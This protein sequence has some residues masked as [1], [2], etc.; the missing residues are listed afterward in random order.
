M[1]H[2]WLVAIA[3]GLAG[4]LAAAAPASA[5]RHSGHHSSHSSIGFH[6]SIGSGY[7]GWGISTNHFDLRYST[8]RYYGYSYYRPVYQPVVCD[9]PVYYSRPVY[10]SPAPVYVSPAPVYVS[11]APVYTY[12]PVYRYSPVYCAPAVQVVRPPVVRYHYERGGAHYS[13]HR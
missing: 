5:G 7:S 12:Q 13:Y 10:V 8:G 9:P 1:R 11:P 2:T 3:I 6:L 4:V